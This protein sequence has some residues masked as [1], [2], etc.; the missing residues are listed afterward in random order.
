MEDADA[1]FEGPVE[2]DL[3][4]VIFTDYQCPACRRASP[5]LDAAYTAD[6]HV[7]L[8]YKEWPI[9]G[10][11]SEQAARVALAANRQ[12]IYPKVHRALMRAPAGLEEESLR[13]IIE[14]AEGDWALLTRDLRTHRETM[15]HM[16]SKTSA[17]AFALG[18]GGTPAFLIGSLLVVGAIDEAEFREA[19]VSARASKQ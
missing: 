13:G 1:P 6:S 17:Q 7:R 16:L 10:A 19:F 5:E 4:V 3:T 12:G 18:L 2:A 15:D 8:I 14:Q 11:A 9:F